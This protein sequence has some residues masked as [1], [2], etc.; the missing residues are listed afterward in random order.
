MR[1]ER[2]WR[3]TRFVITACA[4]FAVWLLFTASLETFSLVSGMIGAVVIAAL[5]YDEFIAQHNVS[6]RSFMPRPVMLL[7]FL[8]ILVF[9]LYQSSWRMLI[10]VFSGHASPRIVHFRTRLSSDLARMVLSNAI[11]FTPGTITLDLNDDHLTVHWFF[12]NTSH[13]KL[14]GEAV[15]GRMEQHL[16]RVWL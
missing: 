3:L 4:M 13:A 11:T 1:A 15:K 9:Y 2:V 6:L 10:A 14:A 16:R 12:C 8:A 7:R 5:T